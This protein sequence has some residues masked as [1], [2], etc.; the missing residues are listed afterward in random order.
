MLLVARAHKFA[1]RYLAQVAI[2]DNGAKDGPGFIA[3]FPNWTYSE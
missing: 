1:C 2:R 3:D